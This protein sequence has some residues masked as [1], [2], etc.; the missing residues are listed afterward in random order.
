MARRTEQLPVADNAASRTIAT[1][2]RH[3]RKQNSYKLALIRAINDVVLSFPDAGTH[4]QPVAIPLRILAEYWVAYYWPF[5]DPRAPI[6][7]G[8]HSLRNGALSNDMAF[9]PALATLREAWQEVIGEAARPS[10]GFFLIN[11]F[12]VARRRAGYPLALRQAFARSVSTV[13]RSIEQLAA[14]TPAAGRTYTAARHERPLQAIH[15]LLTWKQR[16]EVRAVSASC[17]ARA[18]DGIGLSETGAAI[19]VLLPADLADWVEIHERASKGERAALSILCPPAGA[20][21][22]LLLLRHATGNLLIEGLKS[23]RGSGSLVDLARTCDQLDHELAPVVFLTP[24]GLAGAQDDR[25]RVDWSFTNERSCSWRQ[26]AEAQSD[27]RDANHNRRNWSGCPLGRLHARG[28][29]VQG[30]LAG[31]AYRAWMLRARLLHSDGGFPPPAD[32]RRIDRPWHQSPRAWPAS[33]C[34]AVGAAPT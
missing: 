11:E 17:A 33:G 34:P 28:R 14:R 10:D 19:K 29:V 16:S 18:I 30:V 25:G 31:I 21:L 9:R 24:V 6:S 7:Q 27:H 3:D 1:I 22:R 20:A 13:A 8:P 23:P 26:A 12:R 32:V 4:A 2:L 5:V 15:Y